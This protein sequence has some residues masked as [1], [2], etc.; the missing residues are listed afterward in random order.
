M[1]LSEL[2]LNMNCFNNY[3]KKEFNISEN[4]LSEL[5]RLLNYHYYNTANPLVEDSEYDTI[6]EFMENNYPN[7]KVLKEIGSKI[8]KSKIELPHHMFSLNKVKDD[9]KL[10]AWIKKFTGPYVITPKLDGISGLYGNGKL[11]T[12]GDG[13]IGQDI[14]HLISHLK[15]PTIPFDCYVRGEFIIQTELFN[16]KYSELGFS[17]SRNFVCGIINKTQVDIAIEDIEFI[18]HEIICPN[19]CPNKQMDMITE[20]GLK[21]V[22]WRFKENL[23]LNEITS[24]LLYYKETFPYLIDG[25]VIKNNKVYER[26][27]G[28]P[29]N[30]IAFKIGGKSIITNVIDVIWN[31]SKDGFLK[32]QICIEEVELDGVLI[33]Y[34]TGFNAKYICDNKINIGSKVEIVRSGEVIPHIINIIEC[35]SEPHLP[36]IE[37]GEYEFNESHVD[38]I[39][40]DPNNNTTVM[41][42]NIVFF[43]KGISVDNL[44][45]GLISKLVKNGFDSISKILKMTV[46]DFLSMDGFQNTLATKIVQNIKTAIDKTTTIELMAASNLFGRGISTKKIETILDI[47]PDIIMSS[48]TSEQKIVMCEKLKGF[49]KKTSELF[50]SNIDKFKNFIIECGLLYKFTPLCIENATMSS[51][52]DNSKKND[53]SLS[54]EDHILKG[55]S[56]VMSGCRDKTIIEFLKN[57]KANNSDSIS[58]NTF[59]LIVKD[60]ECLN[61]NELSKKINTAISMGIKIY[62]VQNF[63]T[64]FLI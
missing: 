51:L 56:I 41:E 24:D 63:I 50:V 54:K 25:L 59:C 57:I 44:S 46:V 17:T 26:E 13:V 38:F 11:Y 64:H 62:T 36:N 35:S 16:K 55:K 45:S 2:K 3:K 61:S 21:C 28:N 49:S 31:L 18:I 20:L 9:V 30:A 29:K 8:E 43:F 22:V 7:N 23:N 53:K 10:S 39:L 42:K 4:Q 27:E 48:H 5:I 32:P 19:I 14:T 33:N 47:Y 40:K 1:S 34:C 58:K 37:N 52:A 6:K 15:L 12:R 60:Q